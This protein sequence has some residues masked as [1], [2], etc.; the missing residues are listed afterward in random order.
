MTAPAPGTPEWVRIVTASKVAAILGVSPWSSP[1]A[2]WHEM[3][4]DVAYDSE[5]TKVQ[6]RGHYLEAGIL[7][8][9]RDQHPELVEVETQPWCSTVE[10]GGST[11]D[12]RATTVAGEVV[13]AEAKTAANDDEWGVEHTDE[14]P[15][16]YL[17]QAYWQMAMDPAARR[18]YVPVLTNYLRFAEYVV[19]RDDDVIA[20]LVAR[21]HR[22]YLSLSDDVPPRLDD[23]QATVD[24]LRRLNPDIDRGVDV[25][26]DRATAAEWVAAGADLK[27]AEARER[28]VRAVVLE[29]M[30]R[31]Q[32]A[33]T[34]SGLKVARRQNAAHGV[35]LV[36]TAK[37][38]DLT[39][40][41]A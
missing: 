1:R 7:A 33:I 39:E 36:R 25:L 19:E 28:A 20:D 34:A 6:A 27:D 37:P 38:A 29:R 32:Y 18:V 13:I 15:T 5:A 9:W 12:L 22:F 35:S 24:V 41:A 17:T 26:L 23:H 8:W 30:G 3:R 21:C 11:P 16:H 10:W 2:V 4:G 40:A 31:A 14:I